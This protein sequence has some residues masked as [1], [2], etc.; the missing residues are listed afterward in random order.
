MKLIARKKNNNSIV[1]ECE[2]GPARELT[3][4]FSFFV[5]N[6]KFMP[7]F[8]NTPWDGKI[9]L[10]NPIN[11]ELPIGLFP[12]LKSFCE[13]NGY[14]L[15]VEETDEGIPEVTNTIDVNEIMKFVETLNPHSKGEPIKIRESQFNAVCHS[16]KY[17]RSLLVAPTAVGKSF[18]IYVL[19]R[20]FIENFDEKFL[21]IVPTTSLVEQ[22]YTDF[23]D[24]SSHDDTFN[25][26]EYCHQIYSGKEKENIDKQVI[27]STW[28]SIYK[29]PKKWFDPFKFVMGDEA[30]GFKSD[31][32]K[33]IMS[34]C[35]NADWRIGA[36][37][38][39][40]GTLTHK[41]VLEGTFGKV[42]KVISTKEL[43]DQG[44]LSNLDISILALKYPDG[45]AKALGKVPYQD[46]IDFIVRHKKRNEFIANLAVAQKGNTLL[47]FNFVS[48][49]GKPLYDLIKEKV[50]EDRRVF[51]VHGDT[52]T[53]DR[54]AI[55]AIVEQQ[56][57]AIIVASFGTFSTGINI[58]NLHNIIFTSPS[59]SQIRVLQSIGRVLRM[60]D[61]GLA[62][63]LF[64]IVDDLSVG[65]RKNYALIHG[66][67][68]VEIYK[69]EKF[70]FKVYK[71]KIGS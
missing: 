37:G 65:K 3:E 71:L 11:H 4:F 38:T 17:Q 64:D 63:K 28:Q 56:D 2:K 34:K 43:Q 16:L 50:G 15:E 24:Y 33:L 52:E 1:I 18:I 47:L 58:R 67:K 14:V 21:I 19:L 51:F 22:M 31:S 53:A 61:N 45:E 46:E 35:V 12:Y 41:L 13:K 59:K 66:Y 20:W 25:V 69:K 70:N 23:A 48:K 40:D 62:A 36:T 42:L 32:L 29:L 54:E 10:F 60:S 7:A 68:R 9:K 49:H 26:N 39:L 6:Y 27:I 8:K 5:P 44:I 57:D 55:R 30:H